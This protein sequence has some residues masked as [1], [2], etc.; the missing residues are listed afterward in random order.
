ML[1][2]KLNKKYLKEAE[3]VRLLIEAIILTLSDNAHQFDIRGDLVGNSDDCVLNA[4]SHVLSY[5][6]ARFQAQIPVRITA[7]G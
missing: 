6:H 4:K 5:T 2:S 7:S 3:I 1:H